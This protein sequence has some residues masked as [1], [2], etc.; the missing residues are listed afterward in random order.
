[1]DEARSGDRRHS[2]PKY[3]L[4]VRVGGGTCVVTGRH[5]TITNNI[6]F[7]RFQ[8][9]QVFPYMF[10]YSFQ[11]TVGTEVLGLRTYFER[12]WG[13]GVGHMCCSMEVKNYHRL[14]A[15]KLFSTINS[16][17][18]SLIHV[19]KLCLAY[20][21]HKS[22]FRLST[23]LLQF[24]GG[25]RSYVHKTMTYSLLFCTSLYPTQFTG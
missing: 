17:G 12:F 2:R 18:F 22:T 11:L 8:S 21:G 19:H 25:S 23:F 10:I 24:M 16:S 1:M 5:E 4:R 20:R 13:L 3:I 9:R 7:N 15:I 6:L 14:C